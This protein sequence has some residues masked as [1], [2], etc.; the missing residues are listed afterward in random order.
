MKKILLVCAVLCLGIY[1]RSYYFFGTPFAERSHDFSA[2]LDYVVFVLQHGT[3]P[4]SQAG[5]EYYQPPLYYYLTAAF[6]LISGLFGAPR[7]SGIRTN[8]YVSMYTTLV[9]PAYSIL[10]LLVSALIAR[11]LFRFRTEF[12]WRLTFIFFMAVFPGLILMGSQSLNN[13]LLLL[14][15]S[16]IF[17]WQLTCFWQTNKSSNWRAATLAAAVAILTKG[18]GLLL[19]VSLF[20]SLLM[21]KGS[22]LRDKAT[23]LKSALIWLS[24]LCGWYYIWRWMFDKQS[25]LCGN[26]SIMDEPSCLF[27]TPYQFNPMAVV[28]NPFMIVWEKISLYEIRPERF[29]EALFKSYFFGEW[30]FT[31]YAVGW[32]T[33]L[34]AMVL[35]LYGIYGVYHE[36]R[37]QKVFYPALI[38]LI[39]QLGGL[40]LYR[41][42]L[43][44]FTALADFRYV[45]ITLIP[46]F[47]YVINGVR[48]ARGSLRALGIAVMVVF[49]ICC[50][51]DTF[52]VVTCR[53]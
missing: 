30:N 27:W 41:L 40:W 9:T 48:A 45:P 31:F 4:S 1:L 52:L 11:R 5:F 25:E 34:L 12:R 47:Y 23:K 19:P 39:A 51:M 28:L 2:H 26:R 37:K 49:G 53:Y 13:D 35:L 21:R 18:N 46:I 10:T 20:G 24:A 44:Y 38:T 32:L 3:I 8:E 36:F 42:R 16:Y 14:F 29:W 17:F 43:G 50:L 33:E 6:S 22:L 15:I 7:L